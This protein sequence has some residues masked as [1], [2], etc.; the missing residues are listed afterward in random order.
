[1][2]TVIPSRPPAKLRPPLDDA[3][4]GR[5]DLLRMA[6]VTE[7]GVALGRRFVAEALRI[8]KQMSN[9][10]A[11][12]PENALNQPASLATVGAVYRDNPPSAGLNQSECLMADVIVQHLGILAS[13]AV[14]LGKICVTGTISVRVIPEGRASLRGRSA[15]SGHRR[16]FDGLAPIGGRFCRNR[17]ISDAVDMPSFNHAFLSSARFSGTRF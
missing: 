3:L 16:T 12:F 13:S 4:W 7:L 11:Q 5:A 8:P 17:P 6:P 9:P 1:M 10:C 2:V 14:K 15:P